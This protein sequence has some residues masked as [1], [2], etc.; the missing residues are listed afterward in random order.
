MKNKKHGIIIAAAFVAVFAV[1]IAV[2][3][4]F[5]KSGADRLTAK[6]YF[7]EDL[8]NVD[9]ITLLAHSVEINGEKNS[10][11]GVKEA[12]RLG[13]EAVV[14]DLCFRTN[15][16]P[17]ITDSYEKNETAPTVE[18][19]FSAVNEDAYTDIKIYF[20]IAQ[21]SD[22][23]EFNR[24][25]AKYD[26]AGRIY[27][28]GIDESRYGLISSDITL[29]PFLLKYKIV[30]DDKNAIADGTF[31]APECI[32]QYGASGLEIDIKDASPEVIGT[33]NDFGIP[34]IV[35]EIDSIKEFC[36]TLINGANTVYVDDIKKCADILDGWIEVMQERN[37]S[38]LEQSFEDLK[39]R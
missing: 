11:A 35:S 26:M 13:A 22:L 4:P 31:A 16:T 20:N 18:S 29:A 36:V 17:V 6:K 2:A 7:D 5:I 24:L 3:S 38:E 27:L 14:V 39:N 28:F 25:A 19:L 9:G 37:R 12:V 23:S 8:K 15:G 21:L 30:E 1:I 33:L 32:A 10:V 34:F